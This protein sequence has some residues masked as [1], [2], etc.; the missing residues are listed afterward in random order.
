[1]R[2]LGLFTVLV[3]G[4][5]ACAD[6][7]VEQG[8]ANA[9]DRTQVVDGEDLQ[10]GA[11]TVAPS[12]KYAVLQRNDVTVVLDIATKKY[13][14]LP[15][16]LRRVAFARTSDTAFAVRADG[17]LVGL[18]LA[19]RKE[20]WQ[21]QLVDTAISLLRVTET[22]SSLVVGD[23]HRALIVSPKTGDVRGVA[24]LGAQPV[25]LAFLKTRSEAIVVGHTTWRGDPTIKPHTPVS[26]VNLDT[27]AVTSLDIPNCEAPVVV[28]PDE[29]R[30]F[31][32]PTFCDPDRAPNPG[33]T[34]SN[35]DPV[36]VIDLA[37]G[38]A[39]F[40]KNLPGFG[41]ASMS[42]D[43]KRL[44][45]YVDVKRIDAGMFDDKSQIPSGEPQYHI[46]VIDP[47]TL[48]F[49]LHGIGN[50]LPRFAMTRDGRGLLV[51]A[52]IKVKTRARASAYGTAT[53]SANGF[54]GEVGATAEVFQEKSPFGYFDLET[55]AFVPFA[56]PQAGLDRFVQLKD[57]KHVLTLEK[58]KDGL[59]GTPF[60]I[61]LE[62]K[63]TAPLAG[64]FGTGVRDVGI[65]PDGKT[66]VMRVRLPAAVRDNKYWSKEGFM[67]SANL[68]FGG[69]LSGEFE[70]S[71][72]FADVPST[73]DCPGGHDCF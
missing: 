70:A 43:G 4:V 39:S 46:M 71:T 42:P 21:Q 5:V 15:K 60:L 53:L 66:V 29:R 65:L 30:A 51:D 48:S 7:P 36:S 6:S 52:S 45:A 25:S 31:V 67:L 63:T 16:Q 58:R 22:D 73:N 69:S 12:G 35:P 18:D 62:A 10:T 61:D 27:A 17:V 1:M 50:A 37:A 49:S 20:L 32:S 11:M 8:G 23:S 56:G 33:E 59:G 47:A 19:T 14:E 54:S 64:N 24:D 2:A 41:P 55:K 34:W 72:S 38:S 28:T 57:G 40:V 9:N 26:L 44:V 3:C 13:S 68:E